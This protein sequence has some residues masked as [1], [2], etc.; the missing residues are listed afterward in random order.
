MLEDI[1]AEKAILSG[2]ISYGLEVY[3]DISDIITLKTFSEDFHQIIWKC[4]EYCI[5]QEGK[6][7][8]DLPSILSASQG[9]GLAHIFNRSEECNHLRA[10]INFPIKKDNVR[11]LAVKIRKLEIAKLLIGQLDE[12]KEGLCQITG[13]EPIYKIIGLAEDKILNFSSL[14]I[15]S[16]E[17]PVRVSNDLTRY[18]NFVSNNQRENI[19]ISTGYPNFDKAI[20]G[21]LRKGSVNLVGARI[22]SGKSMLALNVAKFVSSKL[23]IPV[24]LL[25]TEMSYEDNYPRL[26]AM[27]SGV[28][29]TEIEN[30]QFSKNNFKKEKI[31]KAQQYMGNVPLYIKSVIGMPFEEI[32]PIIRKWILKS[33]GYYEDKDIKPCLI[34]Y[35]YLKLS[36]ADEVHNNLAEWQKLGFQMASL[37]NFMAKY[38]SPCLAFVQLNRENEIASS[39]RQLW[40]CS[41][42][43][44]LKKK[45]IEEQGEDGPQYGNRK[46]VPIVARH[47]PGLEDGDYINMKLD[48]YIATLLEGRTRNQIKTNSS[49]DS[50]FTVS[51]LDN[52]QF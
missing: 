2:L 21:G 10:I 22:K 46:L 52:V 50:G 13:N 16:A 43:S 23:Q 12:V 7:Q 6:S 3:D 33:V 45:S 44:I 11:S 24:L 48:G 17:D 40:A 39:D 27:L 14:L 19:G 47:G 4:A 30:G 20:G 18:I 9:L 49:S 1:I 41:N 8:L 42:F 38:Q 37:H 36:S 15:N 26:L 25:D 28:P 31:L 34:I 29:T 5:Q 51:N 32:L 35:D